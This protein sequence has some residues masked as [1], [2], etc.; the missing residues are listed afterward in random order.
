MGDGG[1]SA[2]GKILDEK[3]KPIKEAKVVLISRGTRDERES[4]TMVLTMWVLFMLP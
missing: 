2:E 1:V 3:G 4:G